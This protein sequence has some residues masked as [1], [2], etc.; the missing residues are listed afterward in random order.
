MLALQGAGLPEPVRAEHFYHSIRY[1]VWIYQQQLI[2]LTE[3]SMLC[4]GRLESEL[5][6]PECMV[7]PRPPSAPPPMGRANN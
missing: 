4:Y 5:G 7:P 6:D 1:Y 2:Y 3:N